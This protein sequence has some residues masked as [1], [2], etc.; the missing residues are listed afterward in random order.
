MGAAIYMQKYK[1]IKD[2]KK[3]VLGM[4]IW[5]KEIDLISLNE[6]ISEVYGMALSSQK[7]LSAVGELNRKSKQINKK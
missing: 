1:V 5:H 3:D 2:I 6:I 4:V 7:S